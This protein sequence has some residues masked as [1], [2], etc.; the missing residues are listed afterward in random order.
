MWQK[1]S[2]YFE[3]IRG[4]R[5]HERIAEWFQWLAERLE[6]QEARDPIEPAHTKHAAW[7]PATRDRHGIR[8]QA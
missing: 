3:E 6:E 2:T 5:S 7:K 8:H 4:E 1:L